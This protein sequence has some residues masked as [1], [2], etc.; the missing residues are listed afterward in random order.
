MEALTSRAKSILFQPRETWKEIDG[1]F[2]KPGQVWGKYILPLAAIGPLASTLSWLIFGKPVPMTSLTNPV[3]ITTAVTR[4][5]AEYV[6]ALLSVVVLVQAFSFLA[7]SFG[8]QKNDV[9]ALKVTAY[10]YTPA[11]IGGVFAIL[12]ALWP[13]K[14][15]FYLYTFVLLI[16][17]LPVLMK[18]PRQQSGGFAAVGTIVAIV[19]F[20]LAR[21]V[22]QVF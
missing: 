1:E 20:L 17:G 2:T 12:P 14:W 4:G 10:S 11:W 21:A 8:G 13:V 19:V 6:V 15:I 22:L 9:Q 18:V 7:P 5:V 16:I 3:S